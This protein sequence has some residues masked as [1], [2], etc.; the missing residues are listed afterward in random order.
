MPASRSIRP[1][2]SLHVGK[3]FLFHSRSVRSKSVN[4]PPVTSQSAMISAVSLPGR[5]AMSRESNYRRD[6]ESQDDDDDDLSEDDY[7]E[8][9][10]CRENLDD[11]TASLAKWS[12]MEL[13][14]AG[15]EEAGGRKAEDQPENHQ[16]KQPHQHR[17][18]Q[19]QQLKEPHVTFRRV[20][21]LRE[22]VLQHG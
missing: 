1:S 16:H 2:V 11:E 8:F 15:A 19:Q 10:D 14:A 3:L 4:S 18:D 12:S 7:D 22:S 5:S 9:F 20:Q 13:V 17:Q 6:S 21:S